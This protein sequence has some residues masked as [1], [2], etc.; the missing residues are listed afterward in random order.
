MTQETNR[1][2]RLWLSHWKVNTDW[3]KWSSIEGKPL[4]L[5][6]SKIQSHRQTKNFQKNLFITHL[7]CCRHWKVFLDKGHPLQRGFTFWEPCIL[8]FAI[9]N[10]PTSRHLN[11]ISYNLITLNSLRQQQ[12]SCSIFGAYITT[13]TNTIEHNN[14]VPA[15]LPT[16]LQQIFLAGREGG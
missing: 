15:D 2:E 13:M 5:P 10:P 7:S 3:E 12:N 6:N 9:R 11:Y 8:D 16:L 14:K 4:A 1:R